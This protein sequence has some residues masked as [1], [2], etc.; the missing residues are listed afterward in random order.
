MILYHSGVRQNA[1][2]ATYPYA[3]EI[4]NCEDLIKVAGYDNTCAKCKDNYRKNDNFL[5]ADCSMFDVDNT[6]SENPAEWVYPENVRKMFQ[7]VAFYVV[8]SRNHMKAKNGKAARPKFHIYFED[9]VFT[10]ID[11][12]TKH[13]QT[14]C[15][16]F[17]AFDPNAKDAAR[18]FFGVEN[19]QVEYFDGNV[20]L[21]DFMKTVTMTADSFSE[22][23]APQK[24]NN[25]NCSKSLSIDS[26]VP[27]GCRNSTLISYA[28]CVLKRHGDMS[29]TAHKLY[30]E[31]SEYCSPR[32]DKDEVRRIWESALKFYRD[33]IKTSCDY[34]EPE[35]FNGTSNMIASVKEDFIL[36]VKD[37]QAISSLLTQFYMNKTVDNA[38][39]CL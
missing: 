23:P 2:N 30:I 1:K 33:K 15:N 19:P 20:L 39:H 34:I 4:K 14:I 5:G 36:D 32:L 28:A 25:A 24:S 37:G 16:Y 9:K 27:E 21:S 6:H 17:T 10:S 26:V 8:Y 3:V 38:F 29:E 31:R 11:E 22:T 18:F 7:N 12:Y 13:K 35:L